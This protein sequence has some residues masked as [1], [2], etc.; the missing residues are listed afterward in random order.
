MPKRSIA[1]D[2]NGAQRNL[3]RRT[4]LAFIAL[5]RDAEASRRSSPAAS[6][7]TMPLRL[8]KFSS[9]S[10][11]PSMCAVIESRTA[12]CPAPIAESLRAGRADSCPRP[13]ST[14]TQRCIELVA[15]AHVDRAGGRKVAGLRVV[16]ALAI[17]DRFDELG[18]DEVDVRVALAVAVRR[19]VHGY[20]IDARREIRAVIEIEAAQEILIRFAVAAVLRD[21]QSGH[22]L[23]QLAGAQHR[24]QI[25]LLLR[26]DALTRG[27]RF[28]L[29]SIQLTCD[30]DFF[31]HRGGDAAGKHSM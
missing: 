10:H 3:I 6:S 23:E 31:E 9:S 2:C 13:P 26:H 25:Q 27:E 29:K 17:L 21:D 5:R 12:A 8:R 22:D 20:A 14:T 18:N 16:R 7:A 30:R 4:P 1:P 28:P 19:H 15:I 24:P 11:G